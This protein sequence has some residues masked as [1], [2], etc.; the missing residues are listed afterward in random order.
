GEGSAMADVFRPMVKGKR[1]RYYYWKVRDPETKRWTKVALEVSDKQVARKR[2]SEFQRQAE[3]S[4]AG[5]LD[6]LRGGPLAQALA[7]DPRD[8]EQRGRSGSYRLQ[9][10][11]EVIR[12]ALHCAGRPGPGRMGRGRM[13]DCR[14]LLDG[15][16]PGVIAVAR[17]DDFMAS[18]PPGQSARTRNCY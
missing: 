3:R 13:D 15:L 7:E 1:S 5:L 12:V 6:P 9:V 2:L 17:V 4:A 8:L 16:T 18:L 11:R 14:A 10:E